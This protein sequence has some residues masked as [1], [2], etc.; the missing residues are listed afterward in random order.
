M[1]MVQ[2]LAMM[3]SSSGLLQHMAQQA[4]QLRGVAVQMF[5]V[6]MDGLKSNQKNS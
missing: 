1:S 3:V 6:L 4:N 5:D 2:G